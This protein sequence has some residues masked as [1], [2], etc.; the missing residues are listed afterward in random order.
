MQ[1]LDTTPPA[2]L[3][4]LIRESLLGNGVMPIN[5][6]ERIRLQEQRGKPKRPLPDNSWN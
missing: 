4:N 3:Q 5:V 6:L 1:S 2:Y